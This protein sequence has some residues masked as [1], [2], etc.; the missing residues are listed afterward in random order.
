LIRYLTFEEVV[1]I[2]Q[3]VEPGRSLKDPGLLSSAV[4]QPQATS[5][6]RELYPTVVAK[7]A[8]LYR[9]I[10]YNH[11]FDNANKRTGWNS[12]QVFLSM[13]GSPIEQVGD[14]EAA[15]FATHAVAN[16]IPVADIG[17]WLAERLL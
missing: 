13:N 4:Y 2:N 7:A 12:T 9:G 1:E 5:Y 14:L 3:E 8:V 15:D 11:A 17:I 10:A 16:S 6:G